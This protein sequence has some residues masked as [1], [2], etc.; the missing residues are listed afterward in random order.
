MTSAAALLLLAA[1]C[2]GLNTASGAVEPTFEHCCRLG[3]RS[4]RDGRVCV[5]SS[6]PVPDVAAEEQAMCAAVRA[7]CCSRKQRQMRCSAG[8]EAAKNQQPC[9]LQRSAPSQVFYKD[10]CEGCKLGL[11]VGPMGMGCSFTR[12]KFGH[13]W[14]NSFLSCCSD[15]SPVDPVIPSLR[16][17][18]PDGSQHVVESDSENI[19]DLFV[20]QLC[21]HLCVSVP[22]SYRCECRPGF[23]LGPDAKSCTLD[24]GRDRCQEN[25]PCGDICTDT[26]VDVRCSC[27]PGFQLAPDQVNCLDVDECL[28]RVHECRPG[29]ICFNEP[30]AYGC[31]DRVSR[32]VYRPGPAAPDQ[33]RAT[34][35]RD[36]DTEDGE[37]VCPEGYTLNQANKLCDDVDECAD[38]SSCGDKACQNSV[39]S[40]QC[41]AQI[42]PCPTGFVF[43]PNLQTCVDIDECLEGTSTCDPTSEFC[44]NTQ[45]SF[46]C[47]T[48]RGPQDCP[49]GYKYDQTTT[50]CLDV[51][52]CGE[53]IDGCSPDSE[54]CRNT[55]GGYECD[56]KCESGFS[57]SVASRSCVDV[58][59]CAE[60]LD[61][62]QASETCQNV[63]GG[64]RCRLRAR[65]PPGYRPS[66]L[67]GV[68]C[69]DIDECDERLDNCSR[70]E[71]QICQNTE[72]GFNCIIRC[73]AGYRFSPAAGACADIDECADG[74][75]NCTAASTCVNTEGGFSCRPN[76]PAGFRPTV[77]G[78]CDDIDECAEGTDNCRLGQ[79]CSNRPGS[80]SCV[81]N[82]TCDAGLQ[83]SYASRKCEDVDECAAGTHGCNL[84][85]HTCTNTVGSFTCIARLPACRSGYRYSSVLR[86]CVDIDECKEGTATCNTALE[87]CV[88]TIGDFQC[89]KRIDPIQCATGFQLNPVTGICEDVDE[90]AEQ[91]DSC[92]PLLQCVNI[93]GSFTCSRSSY[94]R[95]QPGR[96][97]HRLDDRCPAGFKFLAGRCRDIDECAEGTHLC[98]RATERCVNEE[99]GYRCREARAPPEPPRGS[100]DCD[101]GFRLS[102]TFGRCLDVDECREQPGVCGPQGACVNTRGSFSCQCDLGFKSDKETKRCVDVNECQ[103]DIHSCVDQQRCDNTIG[104][105]SCIR[106]SGCGT[107]YTLNSQLG[108]CEDDDECELGRDNCA[109]LGA[110]WVCNNIE[111]SFRCVRKRCN[112]GEKLTADGRCVTVDCR[113][114]YRPD[115][116]GRC[117]DIDECE[118]EPCGANSRCTNTPGSYT[119]VS[120]LQCRTGY[121]PAED[122]TVCV[123][124]DECSEARSTCTADQTCTN[125]PGGYECS[126]QTGYIINR[127]NQCEDVNECLTYGDKVCGGSSQCVNTPGSYLCRCSEGYKQ[128][129]N[130]RICVDMDECEERPG[131]CHQKCHN[132]WGS[133]KCACNDGY[134]L[135]T[136]KRNC[137]DVDECEEA[138]QLSYGSLCIGLCVNE[139][140]SFRCE[141]PQ[142][143]VL[144][145]ESRQCQDI[146]E[147]SSG[148][149][150][151]ADEV[152]LNTRGGFRCNRIDCPP[153]YE[154]DDAHRNR[155]VEEDG[156]Y[157]CRKVCR[158]GDAACQRSRTLTH[159][160]QFVALASQPVVL[161]PRPLTTLGALGSHGGLFTTRFHLASGNEENY[162]QLQE[163]LMGPRT[164]TLLLVRPVTGPLT[165][166]VTLTMTVSRRGQLHTEH[167]AVVEVDVGRYEF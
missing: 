13:P 75:S 72:G 161:R 76:C 52:E 145:P 84:R 9:Q 142:G 10:C 26:G 104:S 54:V 61:N 114:G 60:R 45:G 99:G 67:Y 22:G 89:N 16:P 34:D 158:P 151:R 93:R 66:L 64:F 12:F 87:Y 131:I 118:G 143:Y 40:F 132:T 42:S 58:D 154:R 65:C 115:R 153:N 24:P 98:N 46:T 96:R 144:G 136:D 17:T 37:S 139:P 29:H 49:A 5:V 148:S 71:G 140:G 78:G 48:R 14:E 62:C 28:T 31:L 165:L 150:C 8:T 80:F 135:H 32:E 73:Q 97:P 38:P 134:R 74:L 157:V 116:A 44:V 79:T 100:T 82:T 47:Q 23:A 130:P 113:P 69:E 126:C 122:G 30:G 163:N 4:A 111:G 105:F 128:G 94:N 119:C 162:L 133:Y 103:L 146:N 3:S 147:C 102:T 20:G 152:C 15:R 77:S 68:D 120:L 90:C 56:V 53:Q 124:I 59:E 109:S 39:G 101:D 83:Y 1:L 127:F 123:D 18:L 19:C 25:N 88:N 166:R 21:A 57:Y 27:R 33:A 129:P 156:S 11:L 81:A 125:K 51:D 106:T 7:I 63:P 141:C 35:G 43:N 91:L 112:Y 86:E 121:Q 6:T 149:V 159:S 167:V 85:T 41:I 138:R 117:R 107:G 95:T 55:V 70:S 108:I 160:Y 110:K 50:T 155:Q 164:G 92:P 2:A 36:P 137:V